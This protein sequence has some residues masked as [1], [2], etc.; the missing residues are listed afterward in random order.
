M[1]ITGDQVD[2]VIILQRGCIELVRFTA[3]HKPDFWEGADKS[4]ARRNQKENPAF[5]RDSFVKFSRP[6]QESHT[7]S[8]VRDLGLSVEVFGEIH[9][10]DMIGLEPMLSGISW[11]LS[12]RVK[13]DG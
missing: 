3:T 1:Q 6:M 10:G 2:E 11:N 5:D 7:P 13:L 4:N 12:L 8:A 9:S